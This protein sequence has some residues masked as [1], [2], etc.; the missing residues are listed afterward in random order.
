M[1]STGDGAGVQGH[2]GGGL[3]AASWKVPPSCATSPENPSGG[4]RADVEYPR[5]NMR[6]DNITPTRNH[7]APGSV[8]GGGLTAAS[9]KAKNKKVK[10]T[11]LKIIYY[12][13]QGI[14]SKRVSIIQTLIVMEPDIMAFTETHLQDNH[15]IA[16]KGYKWIARN[17]T[18]QSGGGIGMLVK[19]NLYK[20]QV[21]LHHSHEDIEA[22]WVQIGHQNPHYIGLIY[23]QQENAA[24]TLVEDEYEDIT[25]E[26]MRLSKTTDNIMLIGDYNAK[27]DMGV[28]MQN[29]PSRNGCILNNFIRDNN[30]VVL[31]C[32]RI[33]EGIWTREHQHNRSEKSV[34][35]YIC[36]R[37]AMMGTITKMRVYDDGTHKLRSNN[38]FSDHNCIEIELEVIFSKIHQNEEKKTSWKIDVNTNWPEYRESLT[39][40]AANSKSQELKDTK[41]YDNSYQRMIDIITTSAESTIGQRRCRSNYNPVVNDKQVKAARREKRTKKIAYEDIIKTGNEK[42]IKVCL[43]DYIDAQKSLRTAI[44][45]VEQ[46]KARQTLEKIA[47]TGGTGSRSFWALRRK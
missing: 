37:P 22:M 35:D 8:L 33:C 26:I 1:R 2:P 9:R 13:A 11:Q 36:C 46:R 23:A 7:A 12:N 20:T 25:T 45:E 42:A 41:P 38:S 27:L 18:D 21:T 15:Q 14:R 10:K 16:Y 24:K 17:R 29:T 31:N 28:P 39:A 44:Q 5:T 6:V 4:P 3:T 43:N 32:H 47:R 34:I 40:A 19:E 30:L